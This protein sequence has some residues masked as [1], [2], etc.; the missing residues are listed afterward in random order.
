MWSVY[1]LRDHKLSPL[2]PSYYAVAPATAEWT[3]T[4]R[5]DAVSGSPVRA[6]NKRFQLERQFNGP[7]SAT[8]SGLEAEITS[9]VKTVSVSEGAP[10]QFNAMVINSGTA[11]WLASGGTPGAVNFG[12]HLESGSG[13]ELDHNFL[14]QAVVPGRARAIPPEMRATVGV[15]MTAPKPGRYRLELQ[16]VSEGVAWFGSATTVELTVSPAG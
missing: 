14:R 3:L 12:A 11:S 15:Q 16:M 4:P 1:F 5:S 10:I 9:Q 2:A 8:S 6:V 7:T 13:K